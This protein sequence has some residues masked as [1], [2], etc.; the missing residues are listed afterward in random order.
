MNG[1][2]LKA[3]GAAIVALASLSRPSDAL[4]EHPNAVVVP[5]RRNPA[6]H[7]HGR[8]PKDREPQIDPH[9]GELHGYLATFSTDPASKLHQYTQSESSAMFAGVV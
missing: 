3:K 1:R 5:F 6:A 8:E 2:A 9:F 7:R 4:N